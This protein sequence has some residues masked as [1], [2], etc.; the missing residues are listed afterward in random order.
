MD[1]QAIKTELKRRRENTRYFTRDF[2]KTFIACRAAA[3]RAAEKGS[4][5][6]YEKDNVILYHSFDPVYNSRFYQDNGGCY[7]EFLS[8]IA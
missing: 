1:Y 3:Y 4:P 5:D 8:I 2:Y 6:R 7:C